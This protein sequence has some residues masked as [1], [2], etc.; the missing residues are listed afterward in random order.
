MF[1]H[2]DVR[3]LGFINEEMDEKTM[4]MPKNQIREKFTEE[5]FINELERSWK[6]FRNERYYD[7]AIQIK[8]FVVSFI[9]KK[10]S[11]DDLH[12]HLMSLAEM[13]KEKQEI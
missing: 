9:K 7:Q 1:I 6:F 5:M 2:M 3:K 13:Y 10:Q 4:I 8:R 11:Y 12:Y